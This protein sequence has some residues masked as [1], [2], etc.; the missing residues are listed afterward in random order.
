MLS[1]FGRFVST[2]RGLLASTEPEQV[3]HLAAISRVISE[4]PSLLAREQQ[5]Y[6]RYTD[7]L[8][9]YWQKRPAPATRISSRGSWRGR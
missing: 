6:A 3:E 8:P 1:A 2:P 9:R 4:S 7:G 5:I